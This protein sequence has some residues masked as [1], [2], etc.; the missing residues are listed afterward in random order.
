MFTAFADL[1]P[2]GLDQPGTV[3][4]RLAAAPLA[5]VFHGAIVGGNPS[6]EDL[7]VQLRPWWQRWLIRLLVNPTLFEDLGRPF[8]RIVMNEAAAEIPRTPLHAK[9]AELYRTGLAG[10]AA[11]VTL[12]PFAHDFAI[13]AVSQA[14]YALGQRPTNAP[15]LGNRLNAPAT[16][17]SGADPDAAAC[18]LPLVEQMLGDLGDRLR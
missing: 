8:A 3:L 6:A 11:E 12:P 7:I 13:P 5:Q 9:L 14:L 1:D 15:F 17:A 10:S 4:G 18:D 16:H 2:R